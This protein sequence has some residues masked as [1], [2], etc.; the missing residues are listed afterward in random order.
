MERLHGTLL[1][2]GTR[3]YKRVLLGRVLFFTCPQLCLVRRGLLRKS[4]APGRECV[5]KPR[6]LGVLVSVESPRLEGCG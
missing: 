5:L 6:V 3:A 4:L 1:Q 2:T